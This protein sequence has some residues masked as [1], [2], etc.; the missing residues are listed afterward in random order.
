[1]AWCRDVHTILKLK[2]NVLDSLIKFEKKCFKLSI[3]TTK[4]HKNMRYDY[5]FYY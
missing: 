5:D 3:S 4:S 1:M 2:S